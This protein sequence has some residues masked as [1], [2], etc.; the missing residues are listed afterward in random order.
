MRSLE[1]IG[2]YNENRALTAPN[3]QALYS[4][5]FIAEGKLVN[6]I[7]INYLSFAQF[8]FASNNT[9]GICQ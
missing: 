6:P 3:R 9:F 4:V 8:S 7:L 1:R 5:E 2:R